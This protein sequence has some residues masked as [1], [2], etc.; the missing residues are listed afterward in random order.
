MK[1]SQNKYRK[2]AQKKKSPRKD[3]KNRRLAVPPSLSSYAPASLSNTL[4]YVDSSISKSNVG[5][6]F[7]YWRVRMGDVFD[8]DPLV[9]SGSIS[10]FTQISAIFRRF[11]VTEY[12]LQLTIVNNEAFP[13]VISLAPSLVDLATV[14]T[15]GASA[16]NLAEYPMGK[17]LLLG[18]NGSMNRAT[19]RI[20]I[21][22][23]AFTGQRGA[24]M[25][26]LLYSG[27]GAS[28]STQ[29][30]FNIA[31]SSASNFTAAGVTQLATHTYR[32]VWTER[33][34]PEG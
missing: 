16:I 27:V 4:K 1:A 10:G 21:R 30:F 14:I 18:S 6:Q 2:V 23:P 12:S 25:S 5:N 15:S 19:V 32:T 33:Q 3:G 20:S 22:L 17:R 24:Y 29:T 31:A 9:L 26:S 34:T 13:V 7:I 11:I 8:P 28:P